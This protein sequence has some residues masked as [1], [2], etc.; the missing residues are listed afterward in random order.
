MEPLLDLRS[1]QYGIRTILKGENAKFKFE[2]VRE[3]RINLSGDMHADFG[4]PMLGREDMYAE[5]FLANDDRWNDTS[6][7]SRDII[8][9]SISMSRWGPIPEAFWLKAEEA[10]SR[11][12]VRSS[13]QKAVERIRTPEW[14]E[15]DAFQM[16]MD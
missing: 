12:A 15:K 2:I 16:P 9:L 4:V 1:D 6:V 13:C 14:L 5:K 10:Y 7:M 3:G 11:D 8:D